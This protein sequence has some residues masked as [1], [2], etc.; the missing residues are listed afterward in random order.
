M[1]ALIN[2]L[3]GAAFRAFWSGVSNYF[4]KRQD[5]KHEIQRTVLQGRLDA[6]AHARNLAGIKLQAELGIKV[7]Q[8]QAEAAVGEIEA[9]AWRQAVANA[10]KPTGIKLV[11]I[12]NG[13]IRPAWATC[14]LVLW[15]I[16][17]GRHMALNSWEITAWSLDLIGAVAGFYFADRSLRNRSK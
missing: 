11:D 17:E 3:G 8:A 10:N 14:A 7:V 15:M 16:F 4:D 12:W 1:G 6:E 2:F 13:C 5:H 9:D